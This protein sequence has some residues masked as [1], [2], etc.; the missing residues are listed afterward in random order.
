MKKFLIC[1]V[2][3]SLPS[4]G[5]FKSTTQTQSMAE[6]AAALAQLHQE[7]YNAFNQVLSTLEGKNPGSPELQKIRLALELN[8]NN[9]DHIKTDLVNAI[10]SAS[11][12]PTTTQ[13]LLQALGMVVSAKGK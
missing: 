4:C 6:A 10:N 13:A 11:L 9:V 5:M 7:V 3:L 1:A 12:D 2:M 8:K